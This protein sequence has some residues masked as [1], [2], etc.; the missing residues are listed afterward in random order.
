MFPGDLVLTPNW[1]WHDHAND[2]D[3]PMIWLDG[4]DTPLVRMLEAGFYEQYGEEAQPVGEGS[5]P[6][7][8]KYGVGGLRP[9]WE[10]VPTA[11]YSPLWHYPLSQARVAL[12]RLAAEGVG[13]PFDGVILEYTHPLTG[14]PTMPTIA[15]Y[16]QLLQPGEHTQAHRQVCCTNYHVIEGSGYS[17]VGGRQLDWEDKDVFTVPTW[18]FHEHVNTGDRPAFLFSFT[19]APVMKALDLYREEAHG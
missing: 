16:I 7:L 15:C 10:P 9:A 5:D 19:D 14:G 2:T 3:A 13:S 18:T 12:E 6:S 4:L 8:A 11:R 17:L 1:T